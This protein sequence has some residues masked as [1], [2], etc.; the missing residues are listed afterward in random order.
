MLSVLLPFSAPN[1][2]FPA[3]EIDVLDAQ[4]ERL[5]QAQAGA[6]QQ[7]TDEG[8]GA[9]QAGEKGDRLGRCQHHGHVRGTLCVDDIAYPWKLA[10]QHLLVQE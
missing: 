1:D 3:F 8:G 6:V 10:P 9:S 2:D 5:E 4:T 7:W